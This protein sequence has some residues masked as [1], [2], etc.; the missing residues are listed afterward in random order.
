PPAQIQAAL[1][2]A[3][4]RRLVQLE[5]R[6]QC[7]RRSALLLDP[8]VSASLELTDPS[9]R[10]LA[11]DRARIAVLQRSPHARDDLVEVG[12]SEPRRGCDGADAACQLQEDGDLVAPGSERE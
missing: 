1:H 10:P 4:L 6:E 7:L 8:G 2:V 12:V 9:H 11:I 3:S 5:A